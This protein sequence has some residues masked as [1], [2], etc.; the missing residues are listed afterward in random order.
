MGPIIGVVGRSNS[1]KTTLL[2]SLIKE[3]VKRGHRLAV[4]KHVGEEFHLDL[5]GKD[6]QRFLEAGSRVVG[7]SATDE[8]AILKRVAHPLTPSE[9]AQFIVGDY[10]LLLAEGFKQSPHLKIEVHRRE[11]GS[12]LLSPPQ[13]LLAVVTDEPLAVD[14]PQLAPHET[15][16]LAD[17]IE[18]RLASWPEEDDVELLVNEAPISLNGFAARFITRTLLGM[19]SSLNGVDEVKSLH[20]ALRR[21]QP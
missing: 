7:L 16:K 19:V 20:L 18:Q 6:S 21:R 2:E 10:D 14:V 3:L 11:Q 9:L 15:D 4:V 12:G 5:P 1:G 13:Q 8:L 17:L